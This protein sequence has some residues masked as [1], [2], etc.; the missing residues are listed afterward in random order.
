MLQPGLRR[1]LRALKTKLKSEAEGGKNGRGE[2][3]LCGPIRPGQEAQAGI[4]VCLAEVSQWDDFKKVETLISAKHTKEQP[5]TN[6]P[7]L[8]WHLDVKLATCVWEAS[9]PYLEPSKNRQKMSR[10]TLLKTQKEAVEKLIEERLERDGM[11]EEYKPPTPQMKKRRLDSDGETHEHARA[12]S[13]KRARKGIF[14][15]SSAK[16]RV[17]NISIS[18]CPIRTTSGSA[19]FLRLRASWTKR[20]L[21]LRRLRPSWT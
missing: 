12:H 11:S 8:F 5:W 7:S 1:G 17:P 21:R 6:N 13:Q 3:V 19:V 20:R 15:A 18:I 4:F 16:L 2:E 14:S 9:A 10:L